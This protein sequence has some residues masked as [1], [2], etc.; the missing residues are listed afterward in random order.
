MKKNEFKT[1]LIQSAAVLGGVLVLFAIVASSGAS[2]SGGGI[3]SI[4]FGIGNLILFFI[5]MG[6]ALLFSIALL[7]AIFLAAVAMVDSEQAAQMYADLKKNFALN[8]IFLNKQY[9]DDNAAGYGIT[10]EEHDRMRYEI[11]QLQEKNGMLQSDI[12]GLRGENADLRKNVDTQDG[13]NEVLRQRIDELSMVVHELQSSEKEIK[14]LV[15]QL[16]TKVEA[17]ADQD[18][19]KQI[20]KLEQLQSNTHSEIENL[21]ERIKTIETGLK[22]APTSG[23]FTYIEKETDQSLFIQKT[24]EALAQELTYAQIDEYLT[25]NLPAELD[26][27]IKD[28]PALT[29]NYI[30]NLR[31]D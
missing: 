8:A 7:I 15:A 20:S 4:I 9:T 22:Q 16:T 12:K 25:N 6:I 23:I 29:K 28:H 24:E 19:K 2:G 18:L 27:I 11:A 21:I 13:E 31:R 3:L 14:D 17:E 1:P 26:K 30:R 10:R 5:G